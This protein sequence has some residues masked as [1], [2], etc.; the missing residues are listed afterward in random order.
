MSVAASRQLERV[1]L[2]GHHVRLEPLDQQHAAGLERAFAP[3]TLDLM[4][5]TA[6]CVEPHDP[7]GAAAYIFEAVEGWE[8]GRYLPF[9]VLD[10]Q[11]GQ[12][13]GCTRFGD[14]NLTVPRV[15]IGW[16]WYS[17]AS[18][19]TMVNPECKLLLLAHAFDQLGC[20]VVVLKTSAFNLRSQRAITKLGATRD[21]VLRRHV[22]QRDGRLRDTVVYSILAE[23]WPQ[24]RDGLERRLAHGAAGGLE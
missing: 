18:R 6:D 13:V 8:A 23:A 4:S 15:E 14:I 21:G 7:A 2:S 24:V 3:G 10:A 19:G 16:T 12:V 5:A 17:E 9:A 20:E 1:T 22:H 11:S